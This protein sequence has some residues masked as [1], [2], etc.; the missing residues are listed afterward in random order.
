MWMIVI[1]FGL[2]SLPF[3]FFLEGG[4]MLYFLLI[5]GSLILIVFGTSR[6]FPWYYRRHNLK[7]DRQVLIG[8]KYAYVNGY[9]HN[10][11]FPLSGLLISTLI[12]VHMLYSVHE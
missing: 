3:I 10:W 4:E 1:L 7:G 9:F 2:I 12:S 8:S 11:D 5:M 6:F